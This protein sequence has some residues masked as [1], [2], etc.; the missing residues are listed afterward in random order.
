MSDKTKLDD[1][2]E[3]ELEDKL[4]DSDEMFETEEDFTVK[5]H[6]EDYTVK[7][8]FY[9]KGK[10][11]ET[12]DSLRKDKRNI[13]ED[14]FEQDFDTPV[15]EDEDVDWD[16]LVDGGLDFFPPISD[17][18]QKKIDDAS[19]VAEELAEE[20]ARVGNDLD[21]TMTMGS[22]SNLKYPKIEPKGKTE[23]EIQLGD[24]DDSALE[25]E[26]EDA[27][28]I[29]VNDLGEIDLDVSEEDIAVENEEES[30]DEEIMDDIEIDD[31]SVE[32]IE[33]NK[34]GAKSS[35]VK[36]IMLF[37]VVVVAAGLYYYF[38]LPPK[39][40]EKEPVVPVKTIVQR[41]PVVQKKVVAPEKPVAVP[42]KKPPV[43][44]VEKRE[45]VPEPVEPVQSKNDVIIPSVTK[46]YPYT[47]HISSYKSQKK[48]ESEVAR[49]R[50]K[51]YDAFSALIEIP[52]KGGW[53]RIYAGYYENYT[54]ATAALT[55]FKKKMR[56]DAAVAKTF[57]GVQIGSIAEK[58]DLTDI[59]T[60]LRGKGYTPY[61][62]PVSADGKYV[63]LLTGAYKK[64]QDISGL[65]NKLIEDGF[66]ADVVK[67]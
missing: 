64:E 35:P 56:E 28:E 55:E 52:G 62:L 59:E 29:E 45:V 27:G 46:N 49:I 16:K 57:F 30:V 42:E 50:E 60:K 18:A 44:A 15:D 26:I 21:K 23:E 37:L 40:P 12:A 2:I 10:A 38:T 61:Y 5:V 14:N 4:D 47:I 54:K 11:F 25:L 34:Y 36:K 20:S 22:G 9:D 51:G 8:R 6:R 3:Q 53:R 58:K 24:I 67:R 41:M 13:V 7:R 65:L 63:R 43:V 19:K 31:N 17:A 66:D 39:A 32:A 33:K 1:E 48:A